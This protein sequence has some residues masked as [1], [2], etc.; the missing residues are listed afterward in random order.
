MSSFFFNFSF[1][2]YVSLFYPSFNINNN[3]FYHFHVGTRGYLI[4]EC[5]LVL[6][7]NF[8]F[9]VE[10]KIFYKFNCFYD[11]L[12]KEINKTQIAS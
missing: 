3:L 11:F 10:T 12:Y 6:V 7:T 8:A 2:C 5:L 9:F 4:I 1:A